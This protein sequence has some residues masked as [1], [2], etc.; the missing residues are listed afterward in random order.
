MK[1]K[2]RRATCGCVMP[3]HLSVRQ[4]NRLAFTR[5]LLM[6]LT[7]GALRLP[8]WRD[9]EDRESNER[10]Q[11]LLTDCPRLHDDGRIELPRRHEL[12]PRRWQLPNGEIVGE[13]VNH[14]AI[15]L[16]KADPDEYFRRS[17]LAGENTQ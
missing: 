13:A 1:P 6:G 9:R 3:N 8:D 12:A 7:W 11:H 15:A 4:V 17:R 10:L 14:D 2:G 5:G 16:L